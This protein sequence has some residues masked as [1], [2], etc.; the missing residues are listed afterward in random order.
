MS[1]RKI[2][3][4]LYLF[5]TAVYA[6]TAGPRLLQRWRDT[7][8]VC[9]ARGW[10]KGRL[11][12]GREPSYQNDWAEVEHLTMGDGSQVA[13]EFLRG[14]PARFRMLSGQIRPLGDAEI[15]ARTRKYYV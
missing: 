12:V 2:A 9:L 7:R 3:L 4:L 6:G 15:T 10:R 8:A 13:G 5:C 14:M 11:G 1:D